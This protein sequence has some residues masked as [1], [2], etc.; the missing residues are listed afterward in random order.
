MW[1]ILIAAAVA[2][3]LWP[4]VRGFVPTGAVSKA[5]DFGVAIVSKVLAG[6]G[7]ALAGWLFGYW[8]DAGSAAEV[9]ALRAKTA[10]WTFTPPAA[11]TKTGGAQ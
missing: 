9:M 7:L 8:Q 5:V 3:V 4:S 11:E 6:A 2:F 10:A 1:T